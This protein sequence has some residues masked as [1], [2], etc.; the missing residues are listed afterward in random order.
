MDLFFSE[1]PLNPG[2]PGSPSLVDCLDDVLKGRTGI[3]EA[4]EPLSRVFVGPFSIPQPYSA[5]RQESRPFFIPQAYDFRGVWLHFH[6]RTVGA[7]L[8]PRKPKVCRLVYSGRA[9]DRNDKR[10]LSCE[11]TTWLL[12]RSERVPPALEF[13]RG[14]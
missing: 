14:P 10:H 2:D 6:T 8:D 12:C 5:V 9:D 7:S 11:G 4:D 1:A 13:R 3:G